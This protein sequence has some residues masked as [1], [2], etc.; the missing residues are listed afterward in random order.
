LRV[1]RTAQCAKEGEREGG[2]SL[3]SMEFQWV[4]AVRKA[5]ST[6]EDLKFSCEVC[7]DS[8]GHLLS[9]K[10]LFSS[11]EETIRDEPGRFRKREQQQANANSS[12]E[13]E[14][15]E[16]SKTEDKNQKKP[17]NRSRSR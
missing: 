9:A 7:R 14:N 11:A 5:E 3:S 6:R 15:C 2:P 16:K 10:V 1:V 4:D 12:T 17:R 8:G 13:S